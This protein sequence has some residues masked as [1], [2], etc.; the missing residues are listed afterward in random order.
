M[1]EAYATFASGGIHC[2]PVVL[3]K[4]TTKAGQEIPLPSDTC[5]R[6]IDQKYADAVNDLLVGGVMS[7]TGKPATIPGGY[8][9][10][11][12]TGTID[13]NQAVWFAGST[14]EVTGV[15]MIAID[16]THPYW[17]SPP[18]WGAREADPEGRDAAVLEVRHVRFG[19][20]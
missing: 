5:K 13:D 14:P 3:E 6:V 18:Q 9:Q 19:W 20:R 11:G 16:K 15:A 12:K 2:D 17:K 7:G 8:P 10:G 1:A 4:V